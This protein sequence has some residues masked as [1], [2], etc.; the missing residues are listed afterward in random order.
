M[1][2]E[3]ALRG[4]VG[5]LSCALTGNSSLVW[6]DTTPDSERPAAAAAPA[7]TPEPPR[8]PLLRS[9]M[10]EAVGREH[11]ENGYPRDAMRAAALYC[12]AARLG[13]P[14][15][16]YALAWMLANG[17]GVERSDA[18]ALA[19]FRSAARQG[20]A[21]A[22]RALERVA[23]GEERLP[24]CMTEVIRSPAELARSGASLFPKP[25]APA[26]SRRDIGSLQPRF[27]TGQ[28][29]V[30][31]VAGLPPPARKVATIIRWLAPEYHVD[32]RLALALATAESNFDPRAI[33]PKNAMGVMQL[34]PATAE[35]FNVRNPYDPIDN[36]RGGL[37]YLRW[38]L[39]YY[40]GNVPFVLAAYNAGEGAVDRFG[41]I[42]P[43]LETIDYVKRI[44]TL[45]PESEHRY[46]AAVTGPSPL[47]RRQR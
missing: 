20:H 34:I 40:E 15:G 4:L 26:P 14:E 23:E 19:L 21:G 9:L 37:K 39:A 32:A 46:D 3:T 35:R 31:Y 18:G 6:A 29:E 44:R 22:Q 13:D 47:V 1:W 30:E 17:R 24:A 43:Y 28:T 2:R 38:L 12:Q 7:P 42:P 41:G 16:Q 25:V 45:F 11:G 36:I 27:A 33:S 8:D 10:Q 5:A